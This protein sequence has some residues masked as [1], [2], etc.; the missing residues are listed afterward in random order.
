MFWNNLF[1]MCTQWGHDTQQT[2]HIMVKVEFINKATE[3]LKLQK[4][5]G[6]LALHFAIWSATSGMLQCV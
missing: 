2:Q 5:S 3:Q 4:Q 6:T 1:C